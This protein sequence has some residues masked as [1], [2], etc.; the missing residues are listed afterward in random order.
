MLTVEVD[1]RS[2]E[3]FDEGAAVDVARFVL[4]AEGVEEGELGLALV[5]PHEI[6]ALK[7]EYLGLDVETDVLSF[8][9]DGRNELPAGLPRALG[10]VVLCPQVTGEA[11]R[12]PLTHGLLHL[13]GYDHGEL[14]ERRE[15]ELAR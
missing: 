5:A 4:R 1:N 10:D 15:R 11:W 6:R 7:R 3:E 2:G 12:G 8:P 13:L 9:I 14:M